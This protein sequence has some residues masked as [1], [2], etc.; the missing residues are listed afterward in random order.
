MT[1][2]WLGIDATNWVHVLWHAQGGRRVVPA[3]VERATALIERLDPQYAIAC[4]DRRSFRHDIVP[5]YKAGRPDRPPE[6]DAALED[7]EREL[8]DVCQIA[9]QD[10]FE[11]DDGLATLALQGRRC[12]KRVILASPD[13][14]LF[15]CLGGG[16]LI[17]RK[18]VLSRGQVGDGEWFREADL[19]EKH[20][21]L[22]TQWPDYQALSGDR[23]DSIG[24]CAG[25]G[26]VTTKAALQKCGTLGNMLNDPWK[27][28]CSGK[29]RNSLITF[30]KRASDV[31][32]LVTLRTDCE[33]VFD[34]L[35]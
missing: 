14:D 32:A 9:A 3:V 27:V 22:P 13:K 21:L 35:R 31:L 1:T 7:A 15:Q 17:L 20:G 23:G 28:P 6:L 8:G 16:V 33:A 26:P 4:F 11:A 12:E 25:W 19:W 24:G 34:A 5:D 18:F 2:T 30:G 10:G 29:Q